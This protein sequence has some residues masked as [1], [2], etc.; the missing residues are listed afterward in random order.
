MAKSKT[1]KKNSE[2]YQ[3]GASASS[4]LPS[5]RA[6]VALG[7]RLALTAEPQLWLLRGRLG[8]GKTT[9]VRGALRA[10]GVQVPVTSPTFTLVQE[11]QPKRRWKRVIHVDG[12]RIRQEAEWAALG[13]DEALA[14]PKALVIIEWPERLPIPVGLTALVV[15]LQHRP[16]GRA[17][18]IM[19]TTT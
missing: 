9:L 19:T 17:A 13:I 8:A 16:R 12:Y 4:L 14:D 11:Y 10:L 7:R 1:Q 3:V 18:R 15:Q 5:S 6:T 2:A